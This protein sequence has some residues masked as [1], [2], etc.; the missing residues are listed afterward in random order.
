M[1]S[2]F[3]ITMK[4]TGINKYINNY[5]VYNSL[6]IVNY[7][8]TIKFIEC[9]KIMGITKEKITLAIDFS[10]LYYSI[11]NKSKYITSIINFIEYLDKNNFKPIFVFDGK[12][13]DIKKY[14]IKKRKKEKDKAQKKVDRF[15][16][17]LELIN[18]MEN[19]ISDEDKLAEIEKDKIQIKSD[20][21]KF[22]KRTIKLTKKHTKIAQDLFDFLNIPYIHI[23]K[24]ADY[25]CA[26]LVKNGIADACL[27]N[28]YDLLAFQ[29]P[30]ILRNLNI[31]THSVEIIFLND[32]CKMMKIDE[33][34]LTYLNI[35]NGCDYSHPI[36]DIKLS[37]IHSLFMDNIDIVSVLDILGKKSYN[38]SEAYNLFTEKIV[39][40]NTNINCYDIDKYLYVEDIGEYINKLKGDFNEKE[41]NT[42]SNHI[43]NYILKRFNDNNDYKITDLFDLI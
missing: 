38:Y 42:I 27:S 17:E 39:L 33:D 7:K 3:L 8:K 40:D 41:L 31:F 35:M 16:E 10:N 34:Q 13:P 4:N 14:T 18:S 9:K 25:I 43:E 12:P 30:I 19:D 32:I 36:Q 1:Y 24:E 37:Y 2:I 5:I 26:N 23:D 22:S 28:D 29:C 20:I 6:P 11:I 21:I 15:K